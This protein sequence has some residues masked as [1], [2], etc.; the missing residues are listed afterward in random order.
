MARAVCSP[1]IPGF[2]QGCMALGP[3]SVANGV[4]FAGSMNIDSTKPTMFAL[5]ARSGNIIWSFNPG[6]SVISAPAIVGNMVF[7]G[8]GY[9]HFGPGLGTS[10]H[11]FF[12]FSIN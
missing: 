4:V 8:A 11:Q 1:S 6:S 5:D 9:G 10:N 7:W 3:V 2:S 12:A